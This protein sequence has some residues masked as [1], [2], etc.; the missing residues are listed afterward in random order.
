MDGR[1]KRPQNAE[2]EGFMRA[3]LQPAAARSGLSFEVFLWDD[4]HDRY[5]ISDLVGIL[6]PYGFDTTRAPV[7]H[8]VVPA[9]PVGT[10]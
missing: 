7:H 1:D 10:R 2:I 3:G 5:L 4:F 6:V 8:Y 9:W